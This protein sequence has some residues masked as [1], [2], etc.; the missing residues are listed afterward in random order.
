[1]EMEWD[2]PLIGELDLQEI[3]PQT[4]GTGRSILLCAGVI[5]MPHF[6][7]FSDEVATPPPPPRVEEGAGMSQKSPDLRYWKKS[8]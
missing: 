5:K 1:M 3:F 2:F 4:G 7:C 6:V 8:L